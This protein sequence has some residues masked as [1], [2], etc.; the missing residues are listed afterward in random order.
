MTT[1]MGLTRLIRG[2]SFTDPQ[3]FHFEHVI[4]LFF[5]EGRKKAIS[6][7]I[8]MKFVRKKGCFPGRISGRSPAISPSKS[9]LQMSQKQGQIAQANFA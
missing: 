8:E 7:D 1:V 6:V 5:D 3:C 4:P 9:K 2:L